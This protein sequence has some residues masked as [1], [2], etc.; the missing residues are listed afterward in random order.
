MKLN[1]VN[2]KNIVQ[3]TKGLQNM[4]SKKI[5]TIA[6]EVKSAVARLSDNAQRR[7]PE[8]MT[9]APVVETFKNVCNEY[10]VQE[11]ILKVIADPVD[12]KNSRR[13]LLEAEVPNSDY[14]ASLTLAKG[15]KAEVLKNL[16]EDNFSQ[17]ILDLLKDID[18]ATKTFE[19]K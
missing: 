15:T 5:A 11:F 6:E 14:V 8:N 7:V 3:N 17:K 9:F 16:S 12:V 10:S 18:E 19:N 13:I 1:N 2:G 4:D